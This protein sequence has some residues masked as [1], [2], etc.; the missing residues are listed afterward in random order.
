MWYS[1][2]L[3]D[4][5]GVGI[6]VDRE[7]IESMVEVRRVNDRLITI[8]LVVGE[9]TLIVINAYAPQAGLDEEV[10][11]L[12][13]EGF[14]EIV[15]NNSLA[16]SFLKGEEHLVTFQCMVAKTQ[17]DYILLKRCDRGLCKDCKV[18]PGKTPA[19][20]Y[21]LLVMVV[22]IMI[23]RKKRNDEEDVG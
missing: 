13:W 22:G 8:N 20:Q 14:D 21:R 19:M 3:K 16:G 11:R 2:V 7:L 1:R 4:K 12:F 9:C 15:R 18:I 23:K 10:K 6:L 17:I 5:N